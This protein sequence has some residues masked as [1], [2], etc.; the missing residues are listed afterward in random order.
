MPRGDRTGPEGRGQMTGRGLGFC[1]GY[2]EAGFT[3]DAVPCGRGRAFRNRAASE[4]PRRKFSRSRLR[5]DYS[6]ENES[7]FKN[8]ENS[9]NDELSRLEDIVKTLSSELDGL[10]KEIKELKNN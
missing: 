6:P 7:A 3:A 2:D 5:G 10:R 9:K 8:E 1:A 4:R